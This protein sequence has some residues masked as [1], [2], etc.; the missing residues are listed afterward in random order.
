MVAAT[1]PPRSAIAS[2]HTWNAPSVFPTTA[3]WEAEYQQ[4]SSQLSTLPQYQGHLADSPQILFDALE[5][6]YS[7]SARMSK[8][9]VYAGMAY[10]VNTMDQAAA[11][12]EGQARGLRSRLSAV[13]AFIEPEILAIGETKLHQ[14]IAQEPRLAVYEHYVDNLF[15]L[16]QHIRSAE[17][18]EVLGLVADP[19]SAVGNTVS[20]LVNADMQFSPAQSTDGEALPVTQSTISTLLTSPDREVRRSAWE[21]YADTHLAFK[22][23][24]ASNL[25]AA[26]KQDVFRARVRHYNSALKASLFPNNIPEIVF[27]N[28]I[29][30]YRR[31]LP[32]WHRYW[33][34]RRRML[35]V[36]TL[37]A[38]DVHAPLTRQDPTVNYEQAVDWIC[39]GMKPL[40]EEYV[41]TLRRGCLQDRWVDIYPNQGK[42]QGAFSS[43]A[44][45]TFPFIMM[46]YGGGLKSMST[47]AHELGH[48]MHSYLTR[49]TQPLVYANYSLFVAE[50]ASNF[51]QAMVR[52][53]LLNTHLD[54]AFQIAV[55]DEAMN[56]FHR[57]FF[58][59]PIL[60]RFELEV[61]QQVERG[62]SLTAD[63]M[64]ALLADL[65]AEGYGDEVVIDRDREGITWAEFNHLYANFYVFQ[66]ATGISGAHALAGRILAGELGA[67]EDYRNFLK[68]GSSLYPLEALKR[69]G[70]DLTTPEPVEKT[71]GVL[72][73]MVDRLNKLAVNLEK[74]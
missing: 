9:Q 69:A 61:H 7:L 27:H 20:M 28:L 50:V 6:A 42:R 48:S 35:G 41:N 63:G 23:T 46:S 25:S 22:N 8:L 73:D 2:E 57:Y 43:G 66:Y 36:E 11:A 29:D 51:N 30:T 58:I 19:F 55:I 71:F 54:P 34:I 37:Y 16:Q 15:R 33:A 1:V 21:N 68:A 14:W 31:H 3:D 62:Q 5:A 4:L 18:E 17:V 32:T 56:N 12:M 10:S 47:L 49:R 40:G 24:L 64:I 70:V 26:V 44:P 53:H 38:Y 39:D 60:A 45:G 59:M 13:T 65:F 72:A 67:A 74:A 52:A